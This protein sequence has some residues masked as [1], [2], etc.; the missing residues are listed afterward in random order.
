MLLFNVG[1][2]SILLLSQFEK[3]LPCQ[4]G[5]CISPNNNQKDS[6]RLPQNQPTCFVPTRIL[7][8]FTRILILYHEY[9]CSYF[10]PVATHF[11]AYNVWFVLWLL[12]TKDITYPNIY[13]AYNHCK[14][15]GWECPRLH[16]Y[17]FVTENSRTITILLDIIFIDNH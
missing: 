6:L 5:T 16:H 14:S 2:G 11:T 15:F 12:K 3:A 10:C 13:M 7:K 8:E 1:D 9:C 4:H 17:F